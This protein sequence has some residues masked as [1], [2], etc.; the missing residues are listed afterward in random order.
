M[1]SD[2]LRII[3]V[4]LNRARE[5]LRVVEDYARF[6]L[7][8]ADAAAA[9]K[10]CRHDLRSISAAAGPDA[11]TGQFVLMRNNA[12]QFISGFGFPPQAPKP[13][14]LAGPLHLG[15]GALV[16][17][18]DGRADG[19]AVGAEQHRAVH[20]PRE[21]DARHLGAGDAGLGERALGGPADGLPPQLRVLLGP[22]GL[23]LVD[24]VILRGQAQDLPIGVDQRRL[25]A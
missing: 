3:D 6:V 18:D 21:A 13:D 23:G 24:G 22:A 2:A 7:D 17:P 9:V 1:D 20:L 16:G 4:N 10:S 19:P 11:W 15:P 8:D 5:A 14:G 25:G 12:V